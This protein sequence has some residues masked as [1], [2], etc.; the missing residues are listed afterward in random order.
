MNTP[1]KRRKRAVERGNAREIT[2]QQGYELFGN[3]GIYSAFQKEGRDP[4]FTAKRIGLNQ[5]LLG[6]LAF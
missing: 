3:G 5:L 1:S 4:N 2:N 6:K